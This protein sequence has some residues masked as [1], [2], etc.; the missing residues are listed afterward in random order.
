MAAIL[1]FVRHSPARKD[2]KTEVEP[3]TVLEDVTR[4]RLVK[5]QQIEK[6]YCVP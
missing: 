1:K 6:T 5:I 4:Q 3:L 2:V